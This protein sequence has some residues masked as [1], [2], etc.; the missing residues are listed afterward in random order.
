MDHDHTI[1]VE[2]SEMKKDINS[3]RLFTHSFSTKASKFFLLLFLFALVLKL[4]FIVLIPPFLNFISLVVYDALS[5]LHFLQQWIVL[6]LSPLVITFFLSFSK[7][8]TS[9]YMPQ[10]SKKR[11]MT[12]T[13]KSLL[14]SIRSILLVTSNNLLNSSIERIDYMVMLFTS[15]NTHTAKHL[16][17]PAVSF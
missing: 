3:L 2:I 1:F 4:P 12:Y 14:H 5:F 16:V 6:F 11:S 9:I 10:K 15:R 7:I 17:N 13:H 8:H